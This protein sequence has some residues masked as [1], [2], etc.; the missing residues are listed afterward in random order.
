MQIIEYHIQSVMVVK[1]LTDVW[2]WFD[3]N[4]QLSAD[5]Q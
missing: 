4:E 5:F 3:I 2:I 1:W